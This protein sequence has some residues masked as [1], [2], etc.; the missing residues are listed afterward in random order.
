MKEAGLASALTDELRPVLD[1]P[2]S[3]VRATVTPDGSPHQTVRWFRLE[4]DQRVMHTKRGRQK[5][6][7][8]ARDPRISGCVEDGDRY[9]TLTGALSIDRDP[10]RGQD[11][12]RQ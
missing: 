11:G 8:L 7:N 2:R 12:I 6:R 4:G 9:R 1:A 5:D 10:A 3:A